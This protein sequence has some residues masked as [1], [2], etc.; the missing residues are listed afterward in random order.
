MKRCVVDTSVVAAAFFPEPHAKA[1]R[2]L[3]ASGAE[4][5]APDLVWAELGNVVWKRQR[6]REIDESEAV[7]LIRDML[8]LPLSITPGEVLLDPA[9]RLAMRTGRTV[10]DCLYLALAVDQRTRLMTS[11]RRFVNALCDTP[12]ERHVTW[13]GDLD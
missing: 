11:D 8:T 10:Y 5:H 13:I 1:A 7:D 2:R 9:L 6:R 12:L 3:L 4:L